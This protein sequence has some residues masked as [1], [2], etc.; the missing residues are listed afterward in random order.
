MRTRRDDKSRL[1]TMKLSS[2]HWACIEAVKRAM[3]IDGLSVDSVTYSHSV[4]TLINL[5]MKA[6]AKMYDRQLKEVNFDYEKLK[7]EISKKIASK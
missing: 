4:E 6:F 3:E 2:F 1:F 5:G 7:A